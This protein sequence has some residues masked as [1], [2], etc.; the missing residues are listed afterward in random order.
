LL[1]TAY[2]HNGAG[3]T[4]PTPNIDVISARGHRSATARLIGSVAS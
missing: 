1:I 2:G 4:T 3:W